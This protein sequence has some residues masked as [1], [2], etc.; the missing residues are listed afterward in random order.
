MKSAILERGAFTLSAVGIVASALGWIFVPDIFAHAWLAAMTAWL[1]WPLGSMGLILIHALTGGRWGFAIRRPLAAGV[2][3]LPLLLPALLPVLILAPR[4]YPWLHS[5]ALPNRFYLNVPF[6]CVRL[7][8]YLGVWLGLAALVRR[9]LKREDREAALARLAPAGLIGLAL[10][11]T[12]AAIDFNLSLQPQFTSSVYGWMAAAEALLL[13]LSVALLATGRK[14]PAATPDLARLLLA[15]L[16]LWAYLDFVQL[17]IVWNSNLPN[18]AIWYAPRLAGTWGGLAALIALLHF[19]LPFLVL[20]FPPLQRSARAVT[21][22]AALLIAMEIVRAWWLVIPAAHRQLSF[23][24]LGAMLA[25]LPL[26]AAL[27]IRAFQ[28]GAYLDAEAALA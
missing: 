13:A 20:I 16:V 23:I 15:L 25:L 28:R 11:V 8:L 24:D 14:F 19:A 18:D 9:A 5:G 2:A 27:G 12:F 10:T 1:G 3:T 21:L 4:L 22:V 17:L 26:G 7:V 6:F